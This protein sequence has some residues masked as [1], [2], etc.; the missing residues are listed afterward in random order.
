MSQRRGSRLL[1][2]SGCRH[3]CCRLRASYRLSPCPLSCYKRC[4]P[5]VLRQL[6]TAHESARMTSSRMTSSRQVHLKLLVF[7][8]GA[9][10]KTTES[11]TLPALWMKR[12]AVLEISVCS[13]N[14]NLKMVKQCL[15]L[16]KSSVETRQL[17]LALT[18][19]HWKCTSSQSTLMLKK[20]QSRRLKI[21]T[22]PSL[23]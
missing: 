15:T 3:Y 11:S 22:I 14:L 23:N 9:L 7:K 12:M 10:P 17:P 18:K 20:V 6:R 16:A 13:M 2:N 19:S 5:K 4:T 1:G 8:H 21:S